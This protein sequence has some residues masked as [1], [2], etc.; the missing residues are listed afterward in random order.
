MTFGTRPLRAPAATLAAFAAVVAVATAAGPASDQAAPATPARAAVV[1]S[2]PATGAPT[3]VAG[4]RV[5]QRL[6]ADGPLEAQAAVLQLAARGYAVV[7]GD[8]PAARAA[9]AQARAAGA[10][11]ATRFASVSPRP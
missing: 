10:F 8:G 2:G 11:P 9:V 1:S 5:V 7:A 4:A 6:R 3:A